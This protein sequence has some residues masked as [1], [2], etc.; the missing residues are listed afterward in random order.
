[1]ASGVGTDNWI[2]TGSHHQFQGTSSETVT[3]GTN[4][5]SI[6]AESNEAEYYKLLVIENTSGAGAL[7]ANV[8]VA[9]YGGIKEVDNDIG[10]YICD[11]TAG[12]PN[13]QNLQIKCTT[14][15][16]EI[17][18][19]GGQNYHWHDIG[20]HNHTSAGHTHTYTF[21][22]VNTGLN[23]GFSLA[24]SAGHTHTSNSIGSTTITFGSTTPDVEDPEDHR[25]PYREVLFLKYLP[26]R[27]KVKI[28]GGTIRGGTIAGL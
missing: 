17:G 6:T 22:N 9:F 23:T 12:T 8:I 13:L 18:D 1:V 15:T 28:L 19:T 5:A 10:W 20:N 11:G 27:E 7:P 16:G 2:Q 4:S 26:D 21:A 14:S 3:T 25:K 24:A